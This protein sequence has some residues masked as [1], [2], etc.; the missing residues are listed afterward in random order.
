MFVKPKSK[1]CS[2][3]MRDQALAYLEFLAPE[4]AD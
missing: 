3:G 4:D 1:Y 2:K